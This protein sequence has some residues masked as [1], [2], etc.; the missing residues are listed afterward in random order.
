MLNISI[1]L[2]DFKKIGT[3]EYSKKYRYLISNKL[4]KDGSNEISKYISE[5]IFF[6]KN[7]GVSPN[8]IKQEFK[9]VCEVFND[10]TKVLKQA[11]VSLN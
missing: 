7:N 3:F 5:I 6:S 1:T 10:Y 4:F 8:F 11:G 9:D 2:R